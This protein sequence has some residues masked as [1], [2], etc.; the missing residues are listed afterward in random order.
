MPNWL[1]AIGEAAPAISSELR[2]WQAVEAGQRKAKMEE[3]MM[4]LRIE[5]ARGNIAVSQEQLAGL[6]QQREQKARLDQ[7]NYSEVDMNK[8]LG[9]VGFRP[10]TSEKIKSSF[11]MAGIVDPNTGKGQKGQVISFAKDYMGKDV[12]K[13]VI[14]QE[15]DFFGKIYE[16]KAKVVEEMDAAPEKYNEEKRNKAIQEANVAKQKYDRINLANNQIGQMIGKRKELTQRLREMQGSGELGGMRQEVQDSLQN[17]AREGRQDLWDAAYTENQKYKEAALKSRREIWTGP[18]G[19]TQNFD[20]GAGEVPP[21]GWVKAGTTEKTESDEQLVRG[22]LR[23]KLG[24]EP[25]HTE[26]L[27]GMNDLKG[28]R[29]KITVDMKGQTGALTPEAVSQE[30]A[31]YLLTGKLPFTGMGGLGRKEMINESAKIAGEHGWTPNMVLRMQADYRAMDKSVANQR[32]NYD[33]MNGFV[34]N[35]DK[36]MVRL[37]TIYKQLPRSQYKLLNIPFVKLRTM[38]EGSGEEASTAAILIELGNE[39]GKL[40]TNSG[41]SIRELSESAQKQWAKVHDQTLSYNELKKVLKTTYNLGHDRINSTK[42]AMD[43][44]LS[45]IESLGGGTTS[46]STS[47]PKTE[48]VWK[49]KNGKWVQE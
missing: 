46:S 19:E 49:L 25:T 14:S 45:G 5:E 2:S 37:D 28:E 43:F 15:A 21:K 26:I 16:A 31:K 3:S 27:K 42:E 8:V 22:S 48:K 11:V 12:F 23:E 24:R 41:S 13:G 44:T 20:I 35:M 29:T 32:K 40:S 7:D 47:S 39:S 18:N 17:A 38:A 34:I 4:P 36:Q 33:A 30:G 1:S 9:S 10:E 6:K